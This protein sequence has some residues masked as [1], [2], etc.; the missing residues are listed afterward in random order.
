MGPGYPGHRQRLHEHP[1]DG[2][3]AGPVGDSPAAT[4]RSWITS[5]STPGLDFVYIA[6][7]PAVTNPTNTSITIRSNRFLGVAARHGIIILSPG[8]GI[9]IEDNEFQAAFAAGYGIY[10][11]DSGNIIRGNK[12]SGSFYSDAIHVS[13]G[14]ISTVIEGNEFPGTITG[15]LIN[16]P[17]GNT[18]HDNPGDFSTFPVVEDFVFLGVSEFNQAYGTIAIAVAFNRVP[19]WPFNPG[20][21]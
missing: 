21:R 18:V 10:C 14:L 12:F 4:S 8:Q 1:G 6:N 19:G 17:S 3:H 15:M 2:L 20:P 16:C 11:Q 9:T 5:S 13:A 7:D